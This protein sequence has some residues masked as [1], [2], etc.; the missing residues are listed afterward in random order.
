MDSQPKTARI[1]A[2]IVGVIVVSLIGL[3]AFAGPGGGSEAGALVGNRA[4]RVAGTTLD[5]DQFDI[6]D[7][8]GSWV[9]VN[10]FAT[11]CPGCIQEHPEL[12]KLSEWGQ[13]RGDVHIVAV[14]FNDSAEAVAQFFELRGGDWPIIDE[15]SVAVD[16]SVAQI[17]ET[18]LVSPSGQVVLYVEGEVKSESVIDV[19]E[20]RR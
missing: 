12:V 5:G 6:D 11:T 1:A 4:P 20:G 2:S 17:P 9:V 13:D 14:V 15:P 19:I 3:L 18:F 10:F 7:W 16:Y 8:R